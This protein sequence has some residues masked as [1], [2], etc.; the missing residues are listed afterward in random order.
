MWRVQEP[1]AR[2]RVERL[3]EVRDREAEERL[4]RRER[5]TRRQHQTVTRTRGSLGPREGSNTSSVRKPRERERQAVWRG[6]ADL[7][8]QRYTE[9]GH[10]YK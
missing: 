5:E 2:L 9:L 3:R 4:S 6:S 8:Q 7:K 10:K 1:W